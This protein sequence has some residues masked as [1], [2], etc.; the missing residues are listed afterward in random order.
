VG[1]NTF[2]YVE[3]NMR[4]DFEPIVKDF[5]DNNDIL[6]YPISD[7][8]IGD[9]AC[10]YK[11]WK[12]FKKKLISEPNSYVTLGGDIANNSIADSVGNVYDDILKPQSQRDLIADELRDIK[13]KILCVVPGNHEARS[14]NSVDYHLLWDVCCELGIKDIYRENGAILLIRIGDIKGYGLKNPS[15]SGCVMHGSGG[16]YLTGSAVNKN[17][18][19][20]YVFDGLDFLIEGHTHKPVNTIPQKIVIDKHNKKVSFKPFRMIIATS[21]L[22][23]AG[24]AFRK[25]MLPAAHCLAELSL[26]GNCKEMRVTQ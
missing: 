18:R 1:L 3:N 14:S 7:L 4:D 24:Y 5:K 17:E 25:Q 8:H 2:I 6:I 10:M 20:G 22:E 15:Y 23:Y 26:A 11:E 16:G 12:S 19:F 21:W 13:D 9:K